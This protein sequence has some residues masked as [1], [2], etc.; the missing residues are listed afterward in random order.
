M[1]GLSLAIVLV[2]LV[3]VPLALRAAWRVLKRY[4]RARNSPRKSRVFRFLAVSVAWVAVV[5]GIGIGALV[6]YSLVRAAA[7]QS[8]PDIGRG[9]VAVLVGLSLMTLLAF[10]IAV[11]V[12]FGRIERDPTRDDELLEEESPSGP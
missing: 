6:V 3:E 7:P 11:D 4:Q 2:L 1:D 10:P 8:V 5:G 12:L 9:A